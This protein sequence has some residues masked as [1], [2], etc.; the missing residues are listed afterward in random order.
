MKRD[1]LKTIGSFSENNIIFE[2]TGRSLFH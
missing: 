1:I 2:G